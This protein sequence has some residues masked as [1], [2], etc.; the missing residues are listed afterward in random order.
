MDT[1][2]EWKKDASFWVI[3][4][5]VVRREPMERNERRLSAWMG[6]EILIGWIAL[7]ILI[8]GVAG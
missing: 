3:P 7:I 5:S 2:A 4:P 6:W 8:M 1:C